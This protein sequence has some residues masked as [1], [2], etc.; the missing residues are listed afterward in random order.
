[1]SW[2]EQRIH[3]GFPSKCDP[4]LFPF[5][6]P[7]PPPKRLH[8]SPDRGPYYVKLFRCRSPYLE[9]RVIYVYNCI[10]NWWC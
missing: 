10:Q 7:T 9:E 4:F 8:R 6:G 1:M 5:A 3:L 2:T